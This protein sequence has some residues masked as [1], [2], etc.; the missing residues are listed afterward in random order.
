MPMGGSAVM[1]HADG[2]HEVKLRSPAFSYGSDDALNRTL[3]FAQTSPN[4]LTLTG[5]PCNQEHEGEP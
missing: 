1:L 3:L 4:P 5:E 2:L